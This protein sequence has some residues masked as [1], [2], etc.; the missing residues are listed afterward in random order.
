M[1][2]PRATAQLI[3]AFDGTALRIEAAGANGARQRIEGVSFSDLPFEIK[4]ALTDQLDKL[5]AKA[6]AELMTVQGQNIQYVAENHNLGLA[7]R[8]WGKSAESRVMRARLKYSSENAGNIAPDG[9][10]K[11]E[12]SATSEK[13]DRKLPA[14]LKL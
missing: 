12:P 10:A 14:A 6:R 13:R 3:I 2:A 4:V 1:P 9:K 7:T 11:R 5:R 8:I